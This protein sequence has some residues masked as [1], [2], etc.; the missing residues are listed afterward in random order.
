MNVELAEALR[1]E[2]GYIKDYATCEACKFWE[3]ISNPH[4]DRDW[5]SVCNYNRIGQ[6]GVSKMGRC[7]K[8]DV[9]A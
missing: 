2:M 6:I 9:K 8:F 5:I 1:K 7:S 3:E 4:L